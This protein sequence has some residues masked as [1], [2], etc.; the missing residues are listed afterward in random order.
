[1]FMLGL[2]KLVGA[3]AAAGLFIGSGW[4]VLRAQ[5]PPAPQWE[6]TLDQA[7]AA[8]LGSSRDL[9]VARDDLLSSEAAMRAAAG[10]YDPVLSLSGFR[11]KRT[12]P[13]SSIL[14]GSTTG[15]LHEG[16]VRMVPAITGLVGPLG[17]SYS[18][19]LFN[20]RQTSDNL[21]LPL[22]PQYSTAMT[23][24]YSQPLL[25][26]LHID[27]FRRSLFVSRKN[28]TLSEAQFRQ[29]VMDIVT[30]VAQ[31]Y[32]DVALARDNLSVQNTAIED[33][34]AL[35]ESNRRLMQQGILAP[36]D[37]VET[38]EQVAAL[39][40]AAFVARDILNRAQNAFKLLVLP[41]RVAAEWDKDVIPLTPPALQAPK[42]D[43]Q[44][45]VH[46]ALAKRPEPDQLRRAGEINDINTSYFR[47][48][49]RPQLNL[50]SSYTSNGLA[51]IVETLAPNPLFG[52]LEIVPPASF[53]GGYSQS[54]TNLLDQKFPT[55]R[56]G[57]QLQ[58]PL[59]NRTAQANLVTSELAS[60][61]LRAQTDQVLEV[62]EMDVRNAVDGLSLAQGRLDAAAEA[63]RLAAQ[64]YESERRRLDNGVSTVFLVLQRQSALTAARA[65][66][67]EA[68]M[69]LNKQIAAYYRAVGTTL[70][71]RSI[72]L[73]VISK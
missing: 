35:V 14:G 11:E 38:R 13:V 3:A 41:N 49:L 6:L 47:D 53:Q 17:G 30:Q 20:D 48:Q 8:A 28:V 64:Q 44:T 32:W 9:E 10:L 37:L 45:A 34:R 52:A 42:V 57:F 60:R 55:I 59:R 72:D 5:T 16:E 65:R 29:R 51:G 22:S 50:V 71:E 33:A 12:L 15:S 25:R 73:Q 39:Q 2:R 56:V 4:C 24:T 66:E 68:Q 69:N 54:L 7:I 58:V 31:A 61:K 26:G 67:Y 1:M 36:I 21:F 63:A 18:A 23:F 27:D 40:A 70:E 62:I 46:L 43:Y 19:S